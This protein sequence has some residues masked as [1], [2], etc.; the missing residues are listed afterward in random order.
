MTIDNEKFVALLVENSGIE[1]E[2]IEL[3]LKELID[4]IKNAFDEDE[5]YE[6]DDFGIFSKLG[7]NILFIPSESLETEINYKYVGMEPLVLPSGTTETENLPD[8]TVNQIEGILDDEIDDEVLKSPDTEPKEYAD[9]FAELFDDLDDEY[10]IEAAVEEE[11]ENETVEDIFNAI[12]EEEEESNN[13]FEI[14]EEQL[15]EPSAEE[16]I[17]E[18]TLDESP[19]E[20]DLDDIFEKDE[21]IDEEDEVSEAANEEED[22]KIPGPETWGI[23][24]HK[25]D[26]QEYAFSGLLGDEPEEI[27][28]DSD[29]DIFGDEENED[30]SSLSDDVDFSALDDSDEDDDLFLEEEQETESDFVPIVTNVSSGKAKKNAPDA[31]KKEASEGKNTEKA[32]K[33]RKPYDRQKSSP[34]ALYIILAV[35]LLG[36]V[37][38]LLAYFGVINIQGITPQKSK[39]QVAQTTPPPVVTPPQQENVESTIE[40]TQEVN[41]SVS[42]Q[43]NEAANTTPE[44]DRREGLAPLTADEKAP[45]GEE[46]MQNTQNMAASGPAYGLT[47]SVNEAGNNGY[48]IVL[49]TLSR[50][51]SVDEQNKKLTE[52]GYRVLIKEKPSNTYGML[53]RVSIGQFQTLTDAAIAAEGVDKKI[54]GNYII[55]KI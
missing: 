24:A 30:D 53:Y 5:A 22:N 12:T 14:E 4:E 55:T 36:G 28:M 23:D 27:E 20:D 2:K 18:S 38:Y 19:F 31:D 32:A 33:L 50:K 29:S 10:D 8:E 1:K 51:A 37:G 21:F 16:Q 54:L 46:R 25:E 17:E 13:D 45:G 35:L 9:P 3:Y 7:S 34:V 40:P 39:P 47:G 43:N 6:I 49:Y 15:I 41:Q 48:T 11:I 44:N 26:N 42:S 52:Q